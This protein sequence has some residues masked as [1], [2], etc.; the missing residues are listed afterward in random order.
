MVTQITV[1]VQTP[2][3]NDSRYLM[4]RTRREIR[5]L[6][7]VLAGTNG[8]NGGAKVRR[9]GAVVSRSESVGG[10]G[11]MMELRVVGWKRRGKGDVRVAERMPEKLEFEAMMR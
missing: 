10:W 4:A 2:N 11:V 7:G 8:R 6:Q 3:T 5:L 1:A 9:D